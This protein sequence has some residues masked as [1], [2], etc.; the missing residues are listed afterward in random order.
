MKTFYLYILTN[1][2]NKVLYIGMTN[3][4]Q[5]RMYELKNKLCKGF[6]A[7]YNCNKLVYYSFSND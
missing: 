6:S 2:S 7:K 3:D 1:K 5:R 4:L